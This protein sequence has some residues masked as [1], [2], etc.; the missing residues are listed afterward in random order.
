MASKPVQMGPKPTPW[1]MIPLFLG[2]IFSVITIFL[3]LIVWGVSWFAWYI[4]NN[5]L[6]IWSWLPWP[7][8]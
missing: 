7:H 1:W 3:P 8:G 5:G 4:G 2:I 6:P